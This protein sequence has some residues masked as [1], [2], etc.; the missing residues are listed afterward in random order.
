MRVSI[1]K[2]CLGCV[3]IGAGFALAFW[4]WGQQIFGYAVPKE[5]L[6]FVKLRSRPAQE[7]R[8]RDRRVIGY[9]DF[10][11]QSPS[12]YKSLRDISPFLQDFV[13]FA[14][15]A[16]FYSHQGFDF[17]EMKKAMAENWEAGRIERG[18]S[19]LTQQLAKN[20][21]LDEERSFL[22]KLFEIP[23]TLQI[24]RDLK[25]KEI[26]ELYLNFIEW[27][28][29][30]HGAELASRHF[31]DKSASELTIEEAVFLA[32]IIPNPVRFDPILNPKIISQVEGRAEQI[33]ERW[34]RERKDRG[35]VPLSPPL[36]ERWN[37]A[38]L[39]EPVRRFIP[40]TQQRAKAF[41]LI[42]KTLQIMPA[43]RAN[44]LV[45][46]L[47]LDWPTQIQ[48][49]KASLADSP[50]SRGKK[51]CV[52]KANNEIWALREIPSKKE[53]SAESLS[54]FSRASFELVCQEKITP[55]E[56]FAKGL[57]LK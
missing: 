1:A 50:L 23:W 3:F 13:V 25:K 32:A 19:T 53:L 51:T 45:V 54:E 12:V 37:F 18:G 15:D 11:N 22:R 40:L 20:L 29:G 31:F 55:S 17:E 9:F 24:E 57:G 44:P 7:I 30:I 16:K 36:R 41:S 33:L 43:T 38:S 2:L 56:L 39:D 6:S 34:N 28:P 48:F 49:T 8:D 10:P 47:N 52:L 27:G 26:L 35:P 5:K 46:H 42:E 4:F 21:F 14:E